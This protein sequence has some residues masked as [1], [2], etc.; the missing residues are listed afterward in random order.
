MQCS[1]NTSLS[2]PVSKGV[3]NVRFKC[4]ASRELL[5]LRGKAPMF[6]FESFDRNIHKWFYTDELVHNF[7][8][9]V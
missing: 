1:A 9:N 3:A 7:I 8:Q 6:K 2:I 5:V 4:Q